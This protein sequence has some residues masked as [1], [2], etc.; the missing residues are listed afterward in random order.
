MSSRGFIVAAALLFFGSTA[1][2]LA[3][4]GSMTAMPCLHMP[5]MRMPEQSWWSATATFV[6]MWAV[7][8]VAMMMPALTPALLRFRQAT[9]LRDAARLDALTAL[10]ACGYFSI[11]TVAGAV[12][13]PLGVGLTGLAMRL[14]GFA[15]AAPLCSALLVMVAAAWQL[16]AWKSRR[17]A[18]CRRT[19]R[20]A[21]AWRHGLELGWR[22]FQCCAPLTALLLALGVMEVGAMAVVTVA[23]V[24]ERLAPA[25]VRLARV[26]GFAMLAL[27]ALQLQ[28]AL[29][30]SG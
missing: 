30:F 11:W 4:C 14:P 24:L 5:W 13:F 25:G 22:C 16:S 18:C 10:A 17:L 23:I 26:S 20:P 28:R 15:R 12:I 2:T 9:G 6:G 21:T 8:M 7:M 29:A 19:L 27:G 3:W 1:V